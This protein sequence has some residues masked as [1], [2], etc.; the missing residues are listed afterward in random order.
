MYKL[1]KKLIDDG[2]WVSYS[3]VKL[4]IG[5]AGSTEWLKAQE[6]LERPFKKKIEKGTL[7]ATVKRDLNVRNLARTIL[8]DWDGVIDENDKPVAYNE[9]I[10][11]Q[12]L[13]DDPDLLEFVMDTALDNDNF[14]T[15]QV[16]K[17]AKKSLASSTG[18]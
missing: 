8:L 4:K 15:E 11:T 13:L 1:G 16:D 3:G 9:E 12:A 10:G 17:T 6:D 7:S 14:R 2:V 18:K 5:R